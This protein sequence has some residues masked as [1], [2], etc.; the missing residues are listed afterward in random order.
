MSAPE[1]IRKLAASIWI[2]RLLS[3]FDGEKCRR[4]IATPITNVWSHNGRRKLKALGS[5]SPYDQ[6]EE[7]AVISMDQDA[8]FSSK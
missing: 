1:Q 3:H 6:L 7:P 4:S 5:L 2:R 8:V